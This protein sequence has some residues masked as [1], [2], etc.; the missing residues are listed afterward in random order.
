MQSLFILDLKSVRTQRILVIALAIMA[1]LALMPSPAHA[2]GIQV[3]FITEFGC[4]VVQW[5][6]GPLAILIF[7]IVCVATLVI[8]MITKMDWARIITVCVIFGVLIGLGSI[9]SSSNYIQNVSGM[10]ACLQ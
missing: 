4:S 6:K 3:P 9:L 8:G 1:V 7:I 10:S 5:L 2:A